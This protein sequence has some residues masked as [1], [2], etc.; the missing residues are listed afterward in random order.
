MSD[1]D[2]TAPRRYVGA[3]G[4]VDVPRLTHDLRTPLNGVLGFA[5]LLHNGRAGPLNDQQ[6]EF[7]AD[8]LES[9]QKLLAIV[10]QLEAEGRS[11]P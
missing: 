8:V 4:S 11:G 2:P 9:G 5:K 7:V 6:R 10:Q 3:D 1:V